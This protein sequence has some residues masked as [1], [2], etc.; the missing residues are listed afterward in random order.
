MH[1][2]TLLL[3]LLAACAAPPMPD[4][5]ALD[6]IEVGALRE[7]NDPVRVEARRFVDGCYSGIPIRRKQLTDLIGDGCPEGWVGLLTAVWVTGAERAE[8]QGKVLARI[9][10]VDPDHEWFAGH[11]AALWIFGES[12]T[13]AG[14]SLPT[15][16]RGK[17]SYLEESL[18]QLATH[19]RR[20]DVRA[21]AAGVLGRCLVMGDLDAANGAEAIARGAAHLRSAFTVWDGGV[22]VPGILALDEPRE[23]DRARAELEILVQAA[24]NRAPGQRLESIS[25]IDEFGGRLNM[26][27]ILGGRPAVV[28]VWGFS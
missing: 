26:N 15:Q 1:K 5:F 3:S 11:I 22:E 14:E 8:M 7:P 18:T 20:D 13:S 9:A 4:S 10:E 16:L 12:T 17:V 25:V 2:G 28:V 23:P 27:D 21:A 19:A 24:R 6:A